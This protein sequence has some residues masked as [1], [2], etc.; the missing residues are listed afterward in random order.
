MNNMMNLEQCKG[1]IAK[2]KNEDG[3]FMAARLVDYDDRYEILGLK[4]G[5]EAYLTIEEIRYI[6]PTIHQPEAVV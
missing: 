2:I 1:L 6:A 3:H 4:N 5:Q